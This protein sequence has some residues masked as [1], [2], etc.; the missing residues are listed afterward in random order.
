MPN[1]LHM[2]PQDGPM[3]S[4]LNVNGNRTLFYSLQFENVE[5]SISFINFQINCV[6]EEGKNDDRYT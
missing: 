4:H 3:K 2:H 5:I 1:E 6:P